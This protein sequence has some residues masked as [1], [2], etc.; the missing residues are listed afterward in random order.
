MFLQSVTYVIHMVT[1]LIAFFFSI[2]V[3][4]MTEILICGKGYK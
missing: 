2:N 1:F 3:I 4:M